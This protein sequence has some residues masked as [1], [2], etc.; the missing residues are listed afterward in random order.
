MIDPTVYISQ[1]MQICGSKL[2]ICICFRSEYINPFPNKPWFLRVCN[3]S[4]VPDHAKSCVNHIQNEI[5]HVQN[6]K[7]LHEFTHKNH[8]IKRLQARYSGQKNSCKAMSEN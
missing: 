3:T 4:R 5:K 8:R 2:F 7:P 1:L 6:D